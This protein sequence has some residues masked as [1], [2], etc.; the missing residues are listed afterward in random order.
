MYDVQS[1]QI[2]KGPQGTLFGRNSPAG[3]LIITPNYASIG[4]GFN[5]SLGASLG[6][7]NRLKFDLMLNIPLNDKAALRI[8][9]EHFSRDGYVTNVL[10]GD[11]W[12]G[13]AND[14]VRVSLRLQPTSKIR[15]DTV[16]DYLN[17][18]S[19]PQTIIPTE[20]L[21]GGSA[22]L[23]GGPA[24]NGGWW[25]SSRR[26]ARGGSPP[27]PSR[28]RPRTNTGRPIAVPVRCSRSRPPASRPWTTPTP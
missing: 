12:N 25:P 10:N 17:E 22:A 1:V 15:N 8:A 9:T 3:A 20:F 24:N 27:P 28:T 18:A 6:D 11:K 21:P 4:E 2:L 13:L 5:G 7:Y 26:S 16:F 23:V 14:S 19:S